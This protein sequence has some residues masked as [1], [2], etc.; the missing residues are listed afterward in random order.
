EMT[1]EEHN[2]LDV[3]ND[4]EW[5]KGHLKQAIHIPH[6]KLLNEDIPFDKNDLIYVH[7]QSGV[8]SS[9]A[10]GILEYKGFTNIVNVRGGY[11]HLPAFLK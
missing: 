5:R 6:G 1:G 3:R 9:I 8:R 10:V 11:Q 4:D 7:C 2:V